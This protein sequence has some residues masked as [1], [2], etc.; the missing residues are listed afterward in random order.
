MLLSILIIGA[1]GMLHFLPSIPD[2]FKICQELKVCS[3]L[4]IFFGVLMLLLWVLRDDSQVFSIIML[5]MNLCTFTVTI[6]CPI[7]WTLKSKWGLDERV[8]LQDVITWNPFIFFGLAKALGK[9]PLHFSQAASSISISVFKMSLTVHDSIT[10]LQ[11]PGKEEADSF[12]EIENDS[13]EAFCLNDVFLKKEAIRRLHELT[14]RY[15]VPEISLFLHAAN[16]YRTA[17]HKLSSVSLYKGYLKIVNDY[18]EEDSPFALKMS[19]V[20]RNKILE[21]K[22]SSSSFDDSIACDEKLRTVF[23]TLYGEVANL[24]ISVF[25]H[26]KLLKPIL[27]AGNSKIINKAQAC[28]DSRFERWCFKLFST[29]KKERGLKIYISSPNSKV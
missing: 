15:L 6:I 23:D 14:N 11:S 5:V 17:G 25:D 13:S 16:H 22:Y 19:P 18:I 2:A 1:F 26:G 12:C 7:I 10:P 24:F 9:E 3:F 28:P 8:F 20:L 27:E 29:E 4:W 21:C